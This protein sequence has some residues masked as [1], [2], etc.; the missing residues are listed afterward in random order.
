M[1]VFILLFCYWYFLKIGKVMISKI[2]HLLLSCSNI[3]ICSFKI[4]NKEN[5]R[6]LNNELHS[7][8]I[9]Q[10][11]FTAELSMKIYSKKKESRSR[12]LCY[13]REIIVTYTKIIMNHDASLVPTLLYCCIAV[14]PVQ[15]YVYLSYPKYKFI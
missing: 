1:Y 9:L 7:I 12:Y 13:S 10:N 6:G 15:E 2:K 5:A 4:S 11:M 8:F 14:L 3:Q